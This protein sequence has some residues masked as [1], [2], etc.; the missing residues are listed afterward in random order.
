M[1]E[2]KLEEAKIILNGKEISVA[3]FEKEKQKLE[4][5][6]MQLVEVSPNNYRTRMFD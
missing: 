2:Q 4:E 3:E 1:E 6:K 5:K